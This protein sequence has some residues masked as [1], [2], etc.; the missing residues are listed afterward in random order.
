MNYTKE[1]IEILIEANEIIKKNHKNSIKKSNKKKLLICDGIAWLLFCG[2]FY[3]DYYC[4]KW[5]LSN[6][7]H[8]YS[9]WFWVIFVSGFL[10]F[11]YYKLFKEMIEDSIKEHSKELPK[12]NLYNIEN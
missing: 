7:F 11:I 3:L 6:K 10:I 9:L 12:S 1:E 2:I 5:D 4:I 8:S